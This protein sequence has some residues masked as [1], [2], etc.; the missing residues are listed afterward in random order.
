V[1]RSFEVVVNEVND[2]APILTFREQGI[3]DWLPLWS[4]TVHDLTCLPTH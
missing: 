1:T 2:H 3:H 4:P